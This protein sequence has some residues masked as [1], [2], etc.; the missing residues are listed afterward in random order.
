MDTFPR[1]TV[2]GLSLSRMIIGTNWFLGWSHTT[3]AKDWYITTHIKDRKWIADIIEVFVK[4][5]V[6]TIMGLIQCDPLHAAIQDVQQR[7]GKKII[8]VST[9]GFPVCPNVVTGKGWD[10]DAVAKILDKE[11]E[12]GAASAC[13]TPR[14]PTAWSIR[15]FERSAGPTCS[16]R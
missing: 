9:P 14:P 2:G 7:T 16:A 8:I 10:L 1:T 3:A 11:V 5:G 15:C 12:L 4:G 13:R 6:D